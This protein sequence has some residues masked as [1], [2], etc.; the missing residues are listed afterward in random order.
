MGSHHNIHGPDDDE[1]YHCPVDDCPCHGNP[2]GIIFVHYIGPDDHDLYR[3]AVDQYDR[4]FGSY[5]DTPDDDDEHND[6][7]DYDPAQLVGDIDNYLRSR[8][9]HPTDK[10]PP[11][12]E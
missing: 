1:Y 12:R 8:A 2:P 10:Q 4:L 3:W 6:L 5:D 11:T 9:N 7:N